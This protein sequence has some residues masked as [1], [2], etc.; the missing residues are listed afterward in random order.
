MNNQESTSFIPQRP[1][2]GKVKA[3]SVRKVYVLA[4]ISYVLFFGTVLAAGATFFYQSLTER[5]LEAQKS[6]LAAERER[7]NQADIAAVRELDRRMDVAKQRINN[8]ISVLSIFDALEISAVQTLRFTKF[9]YQRVGDAEPL[10]SLAGTTGRFD[11]VIFQREV[12][13]SNPIFID[14]EIVSAGVESIDVDSGD[15]EQ[16]EQVITFEIENEINPTLIGYTP[17]IQNNMQQPDQSQQEQTTGQDQAQSDITGQEGQPENTEQTDDSSQQQTVEEEGVQAD[18]V[19]Q[20]QP[21]V[22]TNDVQ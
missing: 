17:R 12:L 15:A 19:S 20:D 5:Q 14:S 2:K 3:R 6:A 21:E 18:A 1:T 22:S 4:Y 16:L 10:I 8:H 13:A 7:F 11:S 9:N